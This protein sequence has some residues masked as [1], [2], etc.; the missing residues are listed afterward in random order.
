[1]SFKAALASSARASHTRFASRHVFPTIRSWLSTTA[2]AMALRHSK[3]QTAR[4]AR[5][6]SPEISRR[7]PAK[8]R[9]PCLRR[10]AIRWGGTPDRMLLSTAMACKN[11]NRSSSRFMS[12]E[13][14]PT[15]NW[16]S[17]TKRVTELSAVSVSKASSRLHIS[18]SSRS[19]IRA[20]IRRSAATSASAQRRSITVIPGSMVWVARHCSTKRRAK[21]S[22]DRAVSAVLSSQAFRSRDPRPVNIL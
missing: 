13:F 11:S 5:R 9:S 21:S 15:S 17:Q 6:R 12:A 4:M 20:S 3:A 14:W 19:A 16:R 2:S 1:M 22:F 7:S 18:S 8:Y 10:R